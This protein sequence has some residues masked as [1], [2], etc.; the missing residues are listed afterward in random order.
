M[1]IR[2]DTVKESDKRYLWFSSAGYEDG[3]SAR[4]ITSYGAPSQMPV[5]DSGRLVFVTEGAL[6]AAAA[7]A[8]DAK[9]H[10]LPSITL[11]GK[12]NTT[13]EVIVVKRTIRKSPQETQF[14]SGQA[15]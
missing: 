3:C 12:D 13:C 10:E 9:H 15:S 1:Q 5:V 8:L 14:P 4:N 6:K 7:N 11:Y 2:F